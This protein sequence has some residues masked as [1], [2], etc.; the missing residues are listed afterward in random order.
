MSVRSNIREAAAGRVYVHLPGDYDATAF[1][2]LCGRCDSDQ[3][4]SDTSAPV[5]CN[6]CLAVFEH[7]LSLAVERE[8]ISRRFTAKRLAQAREV[9][10]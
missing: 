2:T 6:P 10:Q 9:P 8:V 5:D 3:R 1:H 4:I 7:V